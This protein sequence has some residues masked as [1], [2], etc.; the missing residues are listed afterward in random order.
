MNEVFLVDVDSLAMKINHGKKMPGFL[1]AF[2]KRLIHQEDFNRYFRQGKLGTEF[3]EGFLEYINAK[4]EIIG[5]ENIPDEGRFT[6]A[7]NHP[8]I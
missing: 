8:T 4:V 6:F 7:S 5:A 3:L 2:V 1:M